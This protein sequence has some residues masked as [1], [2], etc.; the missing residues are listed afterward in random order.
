MT[1]NGTIDV[2]GGNNS[3]TNGGTV[4]LFYM[5]SAPSTSGITAGR[6]LTQSS[7]SAPSVPTLVAPA[8]SATGMALT[9]QLQ[10]RSSDADNDYL[11]YRIQ[12]YNSDCSTGLQTYDQTVSQTGW[13]GQDSQSG[14]AYVGNSVL[15][16]STI[17]SFS[18]ATLSAGTTYCWR[19]AAIDPAGTNTFTAYSPTQTFTTEATNS[20]PSAPTLVEPA[21]GVINVRGFPIFQLRATDPDNDNLQ[22]KIEICSDSACNSVM[23][24]IDQSSSQTGWVNQ[25]QNN[26][27]AYSGSSILSGSTMGVYT[28]QGTGLTA[29][30]QYWWRGYAKDSDGVNVYGLPSATQSFTIGAAVNINV[31]GGSNIRGGGSIR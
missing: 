20:S 2:R 3:T 18:G 24:T 10:I 14:N 16:S 5:G 8:N 27:T 4:K 6:L 21:S 31:R 26:N 28:L 12:I 30:T 29:S 9:P 25:N 11:Q 17:A 7:N 13:T 19:A 15:T 1:I 23:R 22:Y